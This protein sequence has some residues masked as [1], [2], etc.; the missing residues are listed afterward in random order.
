M[1]KKQHD[2]GLVITTK[3]PYGTH[4]EMLTDD[5]TFVLQDGEVCAKDDKGL[6]ITKKSHVDNGMADPYRFSRCK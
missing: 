6:Y 3:S 1:A 5:H 2:V 4:K